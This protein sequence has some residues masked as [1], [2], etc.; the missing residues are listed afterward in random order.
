M[1]FYNH[2]VGLCILFLLW[3][4][5]DCKDMSNSCKQVNKHVTFTV[6]SLLRHLKSNST[7]PAGVRPCSV[8]A[9]L[10]RAQVTHRALINIWTQK[11]KTHHS[12]D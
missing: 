3:F 8:Q 7:A 5:V 6:M 9:Q 12:P 4:D 10:A 11:H 2:A 1:I